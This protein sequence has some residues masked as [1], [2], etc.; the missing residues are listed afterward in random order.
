MMSDTKVIISIDEYEQL[1]KDKQCLASLIKNLSGSRE[2][3]PRLKDKLDGIINGHLI[4][5][6]DKEFDFTCD[7]DLT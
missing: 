3:E 6:R 1:K 7:K 2:M 4:G 5:N